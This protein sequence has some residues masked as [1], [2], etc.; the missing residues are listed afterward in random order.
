MEITIDG[1][2]GIIPGNVWTVDYI[3]ER[4]RKYCVF[5]TLSVNQTVN[6]GEWTTTIKGQV[7]PA[8]KFLIDTEIVGINDEQDIAQKELYAKYNKAQDRM[9]IAAEKGYDTNPAAK[10]LAEGRGN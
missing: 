8:M 10:L 9:A 4:Y 6:D 5:Q 1:I 7:R 2:G 3:P